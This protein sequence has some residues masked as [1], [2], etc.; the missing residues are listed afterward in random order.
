MRQS[1]QTATRSSTT[2]SVCWT[3]SKHL[4]DDPVALKQT[5]YGHTLGE[6][7]RELAAV[8]DAFAPRPVFAGIAIHDHTGYAAMSCSS[9]G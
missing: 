1:S 3:S 4:G 7:E 2:T 5:F 6:M 9:S 8:I